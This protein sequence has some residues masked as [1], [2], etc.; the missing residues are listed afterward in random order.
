VTE[1]LD[2]V[3]I[4]AGLAGLAC[5]RELGGH[6]LD[7]RV[8]EASDA[9]GG[10]VRSDRVDGFTLDRGFQVLNTGYP[11]L[12]R[13]VDLAGLDLRA[14]DPFL[15]VHLDGKRVLIGNPLQRPTSLTT[16]LSVPVGGFYGRLATGLY[17]ARC[18]ALPTGRLKGRSD[19]SS[20]EAWRSA[21]IP[22]DLVNGVLRPFFAGV[23]LE[24]GMTTSR[25]FTDL[26][27]RMFALG[28]STV[29]SKG[30]QALPERIASALPE[31]TIELCTPVRRLDSRQV[32]TTDGRV[33]ARAVVVCTDPWTAASLLPDRMS[34]P[35]ARGVT[36]VYH[37][38]PDFPEATG[39]LLLDG[40][41]SL[42]ANTIA[43]SKA[44]PEY[45][46]KGRVLIS[47]SVVHGSVPEHVD[48][49]E[50]RR[51]LARLHGTDTS[52]WELIATYDLP[53]AL[54]GMPAPH[55]MRKPVRLS[56]DGD[57]VYVAGDHRDTSSLQGA[58]VSGRR[59]ASAVL[60]D[61]GVRR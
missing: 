37:S 42:L 18:V 4:G 2:V 41:S 28:R 55:P 34:L 6:G 30:M 44:A 53:H 24:Q 32:E 59:A 21:G 12:P 26:M 16:L 8:L 20:A 11:E 54:P 15:G 45:A 52:Q 61:L 36:T 31:G 48:G 43:L 25:R 1:S 10:R 60:A 22:T 29:P 39:T 57:W 19:V 40:D 56:Y 47:S 33:S 51:A 5:A 9:V 50:V 17:A 23:L 13:F 46:P 7:V 27:I 14:F 38:A 35:E 49:P 3:V 58:L